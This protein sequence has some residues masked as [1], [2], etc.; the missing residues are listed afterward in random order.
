M[1]APAAWLC[2][3]AAQP[4]SAALIDRFIAAFNARDVAAVT[5]VLSQSVAYEARGVGGEIGKDGAIWIEVNIGRP[6]GVRWERH[7]IE[8]EEVAIGVLEREGRKLL[9][10]VSRL[11]EADGVHLAPR[12]LLL[13]ARTLA[14]LAAG[15][16]MRAAN[17]GYHQDP[18]TLERM[19]ADSG[20][21]WQAL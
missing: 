8:G 18:E 4:A 17:H 3:P 21:P 14:L 11:E 6:A 15:L 13:R 12:R 7:T 5:A 1:P 2:R 19:I 9:L 20:L 16:G 10:G